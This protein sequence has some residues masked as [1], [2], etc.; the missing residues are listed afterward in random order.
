MTETRKIERALGRIDAALARADAMLATLPEPHRSPSIG[1]AITWS[2]ELG[3]FAAVASTGSGN[4]V[5]TSTDGI[6]WT[7][8]DSAEDNA[9]RGDFSTG[10][11]V[12]YDR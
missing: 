3:I 8:R 11:M 4:R 2:T 6:N 5:M 12:R 9:W 1:W 10:W 7:T